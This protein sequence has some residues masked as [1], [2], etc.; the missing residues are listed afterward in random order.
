MD[1]GSQEHVGD[2][3]VSVEARQLVL[4]PAHVTA[5]DAHVKAAGEAPAQPQFVAL[6]AG[7]GDVADRLSRGRGRQ[8]VPR[9][10]MEPASGPQGLIAARDDRR[11]ALIGDELGVLAKRLAGEALYLWARRGRHGV[12]RAEGPI[13]SVLR[14]A[15]VGQRGRFAEGDVLED[16]RAGCAGRC[17]SW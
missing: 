11:G 15:A 8:R 17:Q 16:A 14:R 12:D 1:A 2:V 6:S 3:N 13:R 9:G 7:D 10:V 4:D 5:V